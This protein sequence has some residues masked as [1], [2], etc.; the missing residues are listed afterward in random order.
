M[1]K[2]KKVILRAEEREDVKRLHELA[3]NIDLVL[4][5]DGQWQ[6]EPLVNIQN[7]VE[8][9]SRPYPIGVSLSCTAGVD[10]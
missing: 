6:P 8:G 3:R 2:G 10:G 4:L 5:S 7:R 9:Q 1:L